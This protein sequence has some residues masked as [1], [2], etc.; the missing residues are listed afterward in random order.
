MLDN[1]RNNILTITNNII[2][3]FYKLS[4]FWY[5]NHTLHNVSATQ[6]RTQDFI[7][8][9]VGWK[10]FD[11]IKKYIFSNLTSK[12]KHVASY[13]KKLP[14]PNLATKKKHSQ[15]Q[16]KNSIYSVDPIWP[17]EK[18]L[19]S[20]QK[21]NICSI[22]LTWEQKKSSIIKKKQYL[23]ITPSTQLDEQKKRHQ[24]SIKPVGSASS[25]QLTSKKKT[26]SATK[27]ILPGLLASQKQRPPQYKIRYSLHL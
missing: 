7:F 27:K 19:V 9:G 22:D 8:R 1:I 6:W 4:R 25:I 3:R 17:A 13:K 16:K 18:K 21:P 26:L 12:K 24:L 2:N 23:R 5:M 14:R 11:V 20:Y 15:Q 10:Y